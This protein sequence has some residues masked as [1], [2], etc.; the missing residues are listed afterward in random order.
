MVSRHVLLGMMLA[1]ATPAMAQ[2]TGPETD[3]VV[4]EQVNRFEEMLRLAIKEA[5]TQLARQAEAMQP[6][7]Q[8]K[9]QISFSTA[10]VVSG[11]VIP[12][13]GPVFDVQIPAI[14]SSN[15]A[16]LKMWSEFPKTY[17]GGQQI[18]QGGQQV[19]T[20]S[21]RVAATRMPNP[22]P[23]GPAVAPFDPVRVYTTTA[24]D[25]LIEALLD[26]SNMLPLKPGEQVTI[27]AKDMLDVQPAQPTDLSSRAFR[28]LILSIKSED[29]LAFRQGKITRDE[30]KQK[31]VDT[32]F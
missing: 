2:Q 5:G 8:T 13:V 15:L 25:K 4:K 17:Q 7:T 32:R 11:V 31:I 28:Q 16:I 21:D 12:N 10:P 20:T 1:V 18:T 9:V 19:S 27:V 29:L 22:D 24:R 3:P 23:M 30:A 14:L 26:W 6:A